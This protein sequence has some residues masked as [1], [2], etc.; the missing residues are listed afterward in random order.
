MGPSESTETLA[1]KLHR[2]IDRMGFRALRHRDFRLLWIGAMLSFTGT[3]IQNIAQ[4]WLVFELTGDEA[5]LGL[6]AF[7]ASAPVALFGPVAGIL[8]DKFDKRIVLAVSQSV[9]ALGALFLA[10]ATQYGFI[11][12]PY[13]LVVATI[14]GLSSCVEM[15]TRQATVSRVVP[16]ED[17]SSAIPLQAM[18]FNLARIIG[19][20]IGGMLLAVAGVAFCYFLNAF[21]YIFL[22]GAVLALRANLKPQPGPPQPVRDLL[23]EGMRFTF[24]D[25]RLRTLFIMEAIVSTF[26]LAYLSLMAAIAKDMLHLDQRGLGFAMSLIGVGAISGLLF[27]ASRGKN[28][29]GTVIRV[30]MTVLGIGLIAF[31]SIPNRTLVL[32]L[33]AVLGMCSIMQLNSTNALFQ[34]ISPEPLRGRVLAM[35]VWALSGLGPFG[36]LFLGWLARETSLPFVLQVGGACVFLGALWGW[37]QK[38]AFADLP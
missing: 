1:L 17:L 33:L 4:Q 19:P 25:P 8:A 38:R 2:T 10:L 20:G 11:I 18:T 12:Y 36:T 9:F 28:Y 22:I 15:P 21:S 16:A 30:A 23:V 13:I 34:L 6:V 3:W 35:H 7:C 24:R 29:R 5:M 37:T 27:V 31:G 26:G 14:N 32:P